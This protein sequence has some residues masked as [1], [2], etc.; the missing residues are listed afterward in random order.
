MRLVYKLK[1]QF[2]LIVTS[3]IAASLGASESTAQVNP[4]LR[5]I[6]V[7]GTGDAS[8]KPDAFV[9]K[10]FLTAKDKSA[11]KVLGKY[12]K[13]KE[14]L[15]E[16]INPMDFP[17]VEI[18]LEGSIIKPD[19]SSPAMMMAGGGGDTDEG[20]VF[21]QPIR[22]RIGIDGDESESSILRNLLNLVDSAETVGVSFSEASNP[23]MGVV[24]G[25]SSESLAIGVLDDASKLSQEATVAAFAQA[26]KKAQQL[27][28]LAGGKLGKVISIHESTLAQASDNPTEAYMKMITGGQS[29]SSADSI[30][31]IKVTRSLRVKFELTE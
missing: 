22:I 30:E 8:A 27:A 7:E 18:E 29:G 10:G 9:L 23:M 12:L 6:E 11:K 16:T 2:L 5:S 13:T 25:G 3:A 24:L 4:E 19:V 15:E 14:S 26:R 17:G 1:L 21:S 20:F 31:K 28:E